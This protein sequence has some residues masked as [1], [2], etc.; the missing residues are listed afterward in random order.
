VIHANCAAAQFRVAQSHG[1]IVFPRCGFP[2][3]RAI[4]EHP[5]LEELAAPW[6]EIRDRA[7]RVR[8]RIVV[9]EDLA[10]DP[11]VIDPQS[12]YFGDP[13]KFARE[14]LVFYM[15]ARCKSPYY[16]G[17]AACGEDEGEHDPAEFLCRRCLRVFEN[18]IAC[19]KHGETA[20]I[21]K[22]FWCCNPANWFCWG[23]TH[24]CE[25]CHQRPLDVVKPPWPMC[26]GDCQFHPHAPNGTKAIVG[27]CTLCEEERATAREGPVEITVPGV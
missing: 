8:E 23:T 22:C 24:F 25:T 11:H 18:R 27:Y 13:M 1:R 10:H 5:S 26:K 4:P 7:E 9:A 20:M 14:K 3:C 19:P 12:E 2:G 21:F 15:C 6:R 17:R 16:G